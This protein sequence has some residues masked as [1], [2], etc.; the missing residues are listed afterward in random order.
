MAQKSTERSQTG[1]EVSKPS[2]SAAQGKSAEAGPA[3]KEERQSK[4]ELGEGQDEL[5][6]KGGLQPLQPRKKEE[7]SEEERAALPKATEQ[8][9]RVAFSDYDSEVGDIGLYGGSSSRS[10]RSIAASAER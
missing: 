10:A 3:G 7:H 6:E 2:D 9:K 1:A 4:A 5:F 8:Q